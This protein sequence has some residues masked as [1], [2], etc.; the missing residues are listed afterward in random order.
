ME[1]RI[2][3]RRLAA[4]REAHFRLWPLCADC[5]KKDPP[6]TRLATELDHIVALANGGKDEQSNRQGLCGECH[7]TKTNIDLGYKPKVQIGL[8]GYPTEA[9]RMATGAIDVNEAHDT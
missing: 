5:E 4:I 8:D 1:H 2:R 6:V 3:G 7:R 9:H